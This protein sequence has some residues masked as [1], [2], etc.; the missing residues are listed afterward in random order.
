MAKA[1]RWIA[2]VDDDPSVLKALERSLR[3]RALQCKTFSSAHEFL[4]VLPNGLPSCLIVDLQMPGMSGL[5][6]L[7]HLKL[8]DIHIPTIIITAHGDMKV[9]QRCEAAGA[10]AFFAKP[11]ENALLFA[12]IDDV[13]NS[14]RR[15]SQP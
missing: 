5:E 14:S 12:A 1:A 11:I 13:T 6:L 9:R 8:R 10:S 3:A 7:A 2:L 4:G 15:S